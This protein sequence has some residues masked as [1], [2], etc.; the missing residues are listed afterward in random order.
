[1]PQ[2]S[3][4]IQRR[5]LRVGRCLPR[6]PVIGMPGLSDRHAGISDR[7]APESVIGMRRNQ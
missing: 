3:E 4:I 7:H 6:L 2:G 5:S 1:M